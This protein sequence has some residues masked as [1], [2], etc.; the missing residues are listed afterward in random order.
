MAL[1]RLARLADSVVVVR[2]VV[3]VVVAV[4]VVV[5]GAVVVVVVVVVAVVS[6]TVGVVAMGG[7]REVSRSCSSDPSVA[8]VS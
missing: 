3:V 2:S 5:V 7:V 1:I 6:S 8:S 4:V